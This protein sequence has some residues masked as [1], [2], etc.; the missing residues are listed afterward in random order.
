MNARF[1]KESIFHAQIA[2]SL[3]L[4]LTVAPVC[5]AQPVQED[6]WEQARVAEQKAAA[7]YDEVAAK[8]SGLRAALDSWQ[9]VESG[10][11]AAAA[12]YEEV[13][14]QLSGGRAALDSR[15]NVESGYLAA[16]REMRDKDAPVADAM[17]VSAL[18]RAEQKLDILQEYLDW[19]LESINKLRESA[20]LPDIIQLSTMLEEKG[21]LSALCEAVQSVASVEDVARWSEVTQ[22]LEDADA[23]LNAARNRLLAAQKTRI[24]QDL[25]ELQTT[26]EPPQDLDGI[27]LR[28]ADFQALPE[29]EEQLETLLEEIRHWQACCTQPDE[30]LQLLEVKDMPRMLAWL[31]NFK[32]R[33]ESESLPL[34]RRLEDFAAS[35]PLLRTAGRMAS[36]CPA[37]GD[38]VSEIELIPWR[39][40]VKE[41]TSEEEMLRPHR[42]MPPLQGNPVKEA[43]SEE[44]ML[45]LLVESV[46]FSSEQLQ[47]IDAEYRTLSNRL[48]SLQLKD[49]QSEKALMDKESRLAIRHLALSSID[50]RCRELLVKSA[51][52]IDEENEAVLTKL[53]E[54]ITRELRDIREIYRLDAGI[55]SCKGGLEEI[56][57]YEKKIQAFIDAALNQFIDAEIKYDKAEAKA[58]EWFTFR[59]STE[60]QK[61]YR[62]AYEMLKSIDKYDWKAF[63]PDIYNYEKLETDLAEYIEG[64]L[65][66]VTVTLSVEKMMPENTGNER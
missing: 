33:M 60:V 56:G 59:S 42:Q 4:S 24:Q 40:R 7:A 25:S 12:A 64:E 37:L 53:N 50:A 21:R 65:P 32:T 1:M 57:Q 30:P 61:L 46:S 22:R 16:A 19:K 26:A 36:S 20:T 63:C 18:R 51:P 43:T 15:Q 2:W 10:Y 55:L 8:L 14:A 52:Y 48:Y 28:Y 39:L 66:D 41:A 34:N 31:R 54:T 45:Q 6:E 47:R 62:E 9:N 27:M 23:A 3:A 5:S 35:A 11:L 17:Y 49:M 29:L 13:A 38:L 58:A 44:E